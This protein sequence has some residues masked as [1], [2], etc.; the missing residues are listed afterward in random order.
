[1]LHIIHAANA[2]QA[3]HLVGIELPFW[4]AVPAAYIAYAIMSM[5]P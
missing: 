3:L 2:N 4:L 1:M 5:L